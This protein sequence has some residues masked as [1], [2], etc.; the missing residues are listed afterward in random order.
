MQIDLARSSPLEKR[1]LCLVK[2]A[3]ATEF[4]RLKPARF[5]SRLACIAVWLAF[6][7]STGAQSPAEHA[8][9]H[10]GAEAGAPAVTAPNPNAPAAAPPMA[11]M[12]AVGASGGIDLMGEMMRQMGVPPRKELYPALM[13]LPALTPETRAEFERLARTRMTDGAGLLSGGLEKLNAAALTGDLAA[14]QAGS[15]Q[16]RQGVVHYQSGIAALRAISDNQA[17]KTV[18]LSW[19]KQSMNLL[20]P[21]DVANPHGIFGLSAFHYFTMFVL[22]ALAVVLSWT[23]IRKLQRAQALALRLTGGAGSPAPVSPA[24]TQTA[25]PPANPIANAA[26]TSPA[27]ASVDPQISGQVAPSKPNSWTGLLRVLRIFAET[28]NVRTLRLADPAGGP[29]PF[30]FLPGQFVTFTVTPNDQ[31]V[32]RSYTI[33]SAPTRRE[34]VEITVKLE[35]RG[36]VSAFL[37]SM[38]EGDTLQTTGPSGN[39]TFIGAGA[40]SIVLIA[41]GV[42]VTPM[43]S[44]LRYLTDRSWL[45]DIYFVYGCRSEHDVIYREELEYLQKRFA[46]LHLMITAS[47]VASADWPYARGSITQ[48]LLSQAIPNIATRRVHL[49]GPKPMMAALK[50]ALSDLGVP[51]E[52]V[53]T[54]VF[55]GKERPVTPQNDANAS[56]EAAPDQGDALA[57]VTPAPVP[58]LGVA[59]CT[60]AKSKRTALLAADR[61]IL[62]ASEAVGV[63]IDYSCRVGTCGLCK[64]KLLA[65]TVSMEIQDSLDAND[66]LNQVIL[67]CQAKSTGDVAVDA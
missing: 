56:A 7:A 58:G 16:M 65:G 41:G 11:G 21:A 6:A 2:L 10:P 33:A 3:H 28:P 46:N 51:A 25:N 36:T 9:H 49:C 59:V 35:E 30:R 60:F 66:K 31:P 19:F 4:V 54:E 24:A 26:A 39:F 38:H 57:P 61:T 53:K 22:L 64:V 29:I 37:H 52:Q 27:N 44:M 17:P 20:P 62:E 18:A 34:Y 63:N 14:M 13:E 42:G 32:K 15:A 48:E 55:I 8:S 40:N 43:M 45:G 47:D 50:V 67:A 23:N 12:P 1:R 5:E